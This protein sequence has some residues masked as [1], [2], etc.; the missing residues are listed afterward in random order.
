MSSL[1]IDI[2]DIINIAYKDVPSKLSFNSNE[3][4]LK[5]ITLSSIIYPYTNQICHSNYLLYCQTSSCLIHLSTL[6]NYLN[7]S[8]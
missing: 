6:R 3:D 5:F 7:R 1:N 2:K 8:K 4:V